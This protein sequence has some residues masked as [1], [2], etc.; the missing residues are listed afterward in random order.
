MKP[1][2][3]HV[4]PAFG[5]G[6]AEVR[7]ACLING[8]GDEFAHTIVA[9]EEHFDARQ[10]L[11]EGA[12]VA[13]RHMGDVE[14]G[15]LFPIRAGRFLKEIDADLYCTYN[16]GTS[17]AA[18]GLVLRRLRPW[19]QVVDGFGI[20]EAH[21][22]L[23]RRRLLRRVIYP[24]AAAVVVV[25]HGLERMATASWGVPAERVRRF[26]NGIDTDLFAPGPPDPA[27][28]EQLGV[29]PDALLVGCIAH[30]RPVKNQPFLVRAFC[31]VADRHPG[32][33]VLLIGARGDEPV[34]Q[35]RAVARGA[36]V[37]D[38]VHFPGTV[39][40]PQR[41]YRSLD[42]FALS[43]LS[44]QFPMSISEAMAC[45]CPIV[46]T[47]VGDVF[48]MVGEPNRRFVVDGEERYA[49]ALDELLG[50]AD[51]RQRLG[52]ANREQALQTLRLEQMVERW[53]G[54]FRELLEPARVNS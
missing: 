19:I 24:R 44:E 42:V 14:R 30:M 39:K 23:V 52:E 32:A 12:D 51:L 9:L 18:V 26:A 5:R 31:R 54:L 50:S 29:P 21:E 6:G 33:H 27:V 2:I 35:M 38:R 43:S 10:V 45:G 40:N 41:W 46:S 48:H 11:N 34:E 4:F 28:R 8:L 20:E 17:D 1:H 22:Q 7:T 16:W 15:N 47:N 53:R 25:S 13:F 49:E 37:A 36:G 3:C